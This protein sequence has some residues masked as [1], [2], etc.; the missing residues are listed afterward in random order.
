MWRAFLLQSG[1]SNR[2]IPKVATLRTAFLLL[3][4]F[5]SA[6]AQVTVS[7]TIA[8]GAISVGVR[9]Q[10][11]M[12]SGAVVR[13]GSI[14]TLTDSAGMA[15]LRLP[16]GMRRLITSH[17]GF[18]PDTLSVEI[19]AGSDTVIEVQL[20]PVTVRLEEVIV[21]AS[22]VD[23]RVQDEPERVEVLSGEDVSEKS[24]MH[25]A[26]PMNLVS[27]MPGVR[28]QS[29]STAFGGSGIRL[30]GLRGRY[31]LLLADGL[32]LY[33][34]SSEGLGFLQIPPLDLAQ[35][36]VIKG[37]A[38]ALYGS[39]AAGGV[40]NLIARRPPR[41][42]GTVHEILLNQTS[43]QGTDALVWSAGRISKASGYT[44]LG[45][46]H[47]QAAVDVNRDHW[48]DV[49]GFRR[50]E[51]RPRVF[52]ADSTGNSAMITAGAAN[53]DRRSGT[54]GSSATPSGTSFPLTAETGRADA[55]ITVRLITKRGSVV[56]L[57]S[58]INQQRQAR[59]YGD[60]T[61]S[62]H[63]GTAF[64]EVSLASSHGL[65]ETLL[66]FGLQNDGLSSK[67][68]THAV[69]QFV[70][71]SVF[72]QDTY[73]ATD[74]LSVTSTARLD[75]H[76]MY[77]TFVSPRVSALSRFADG[78]AAR[79]SGGSGFFAPTALV[80]EADVVGLSRVRGFRSL[81][82]ERIVQV[83]ADITRT[84]GAAEVTGTLFG[85]KV[86]DA[87]SVNANSPTQ[88]VLGL[89]NSPMPTRTGGASFF[90]VYNQEPLAITAL[91]TYTQST[92]W[93][94]ELRRRVATALTP[95]HAAGL[96]VAFEEDETGTRVGL[97]VFYT[98]RQQ[99]DENPYRTESIPYTTFGVLIEQEVGLASLFV[100]AENLTN[101]RQT[102]FNPLLL[103]AQDATGRWTTPAWAPLEGRT[104]NAGVRVHFDRKTRRAHVFQP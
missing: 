90:A 47:R 7:D 31:T 9:Y 56:L 10:A 40:V 61:E 4:P 82:A 95:R 25:P 14:G 92:E 37:A 51:I 103:R 99:L 94:P 57:R 26:N 83:S 32:P 66:G 48:T 62:D 20:L 16:A 6:A 36:E 98:G 27:E 11:E 43:R 2:Q 52:W 22:R 75:Q 87:V 101:F 34:S 12:I 93:S 80:E 49:P 77:G 5:A 24:V 42:S 39:A 1:R 71:G 59:R 63:R 23:R 50:I 21:G 68:L 78:W 45:G 88:G 58:S 13:S 53:E 28:M 15:T 46:A 17:F 3:F 33:G 70:T 38:T 79:V 76:N 65:H 100:N 102:H 44:V 55:G 64:G 18:V 19:R 104:L 73:R 67:N 72:G 84:I 35:A 54:V 96:D 81:K 30:Q 29:P 89:S 74:K 60:S 86:R 85:A 91:Y 41:D 97:E 8:V 69:Y